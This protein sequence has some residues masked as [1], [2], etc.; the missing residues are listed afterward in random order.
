MSPP[1]LAGNPRAARLRRLNILVTAHGEVLAHTTRALMIAEELRARGAN[2]AFA[3]RGDK[4]ELV[5]A[6]G[7]PVQDIVDV[8]LRD[9]LRRHKLGNAKL[10][11]ENQAFEC[12]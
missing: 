8:P 5:K 9:V 4:S 11:S 3:M 2:V 12:V 6:A 7:F 1:D 10:C